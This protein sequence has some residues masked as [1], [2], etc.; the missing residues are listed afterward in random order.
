MLKKFLYKSL[1]NFSYFYDYLSYRMYI[2]LFLSIVVGILDGFG[3]IMFMPL[4]ELVSGSQ[5]KTVGNMGNMSFI[6]SLLN[7]V[8]LELN[9]IT[10]LLVML[11]FFICKGLFQFFS[12]YKKAEYVQLFIRVIRN[13][14]IYCL[15][16]LSF[17]EFMKTDIGRIQNTLGGEVSKVTIA[18]GSYMHV[19][20]HSMMVIV[21]STL[22]FISN[23]QFALLVA[24]GGMMTNLFFKA[25]YSQTKELS[26]KLTDSNHSFQ[27]LLIQNV[28]FFKYLKA[29]A[30]STQYSKKLIGNVSEIEK[31]SLKIGKLN[32]IMTGLR[33]PILISVVIAVMIIQARLFNANIALMILSI[34]FF[35]RAL[36]SMMLLQSF[37]NSY[38]S[39]SGSLD[40]MSKFTAELESG[41][42][43]NGSIRFEVFKNKIQVE[44]AELSLGNKTILKN[45]SL[46]IHKLQSVGFVGESGSGKT[47]LMNVVSGLLQTNKGNVSIDGINYSDLDIRTLQR[48]IG[49]ITQE[50]VIFTDTIFNNVTFWDVKTPE[51]LQRFDL[52]LQNANIYDFVYEREFLEDSI[53]DNNGINLSGGQKQR[54]SIAREL[55]KDVDF[56]FFDEATSAL[57]NESER[58]IQENINSLKGKYTLIIIAHRLSTIKNCDQIY[59][60]K[61]GTIQA[62]GSYEELLENSSDFKKMAQY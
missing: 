58:L 28:I 8:G 61:S 23:P 4:L 36:N 9:L 43:E 54:L 41:K 60:I 51:N 16:K 47:T 31:Y 10:V 13:K 7:S 20:G 18:F 53:L 37:W 15:E 14:L 56:L 2:F 44:Q 19:I 29:T 50:P 32:A 59:Y 30:S 38:L 11:F 52:A 25:I 24:I 34:L 27:G 57:D 62:S 42:Q 35:Y 46:E 45:V 21:Y 40:N 17:K 48:R 5:T 49:Y 12:E 1:A 39:V 26:N 33:E 3:L 22:A 55:Y 6:V